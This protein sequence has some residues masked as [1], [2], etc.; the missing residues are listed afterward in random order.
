M[1]LEGHVLGRW[2]GQWCPK[3]MLPS[4]VRVRVAGVDP[5]TLRILARVTVMQCLCGWQDC[6]HG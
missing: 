4:A 1:A 2:F 5:R 3:C 6:E